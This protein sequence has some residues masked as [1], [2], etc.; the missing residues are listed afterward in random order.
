MTGKLK[1][2]KRRRREGKT[3]YNLRKK[4]LKGNLPRVTVRKTNKYIILSYVTSQEARDKVLISISSKKLLNY[5]WPEELKGSLKS[6][7]AA[8][9][10]GLLFG[11]KISEKELNKKIILDLGLNRNIAKSR[12]YSVVKGLKDA[13]I[14]IKCSEKIFPNEERTKGEHMKKNIKDIF[15]KIK[16]NIDTGRK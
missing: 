6:I 4:L 10:S 8:Y 9:L 2:K 14:D 11:K 16:Q 1:I 7:P 15:D 12:I 3:N 5:G 13:E